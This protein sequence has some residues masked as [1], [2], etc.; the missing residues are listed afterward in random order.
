[1][2]RIRRWLAIEWVMIFIDTLILYGIDERYQHEH[3]GD[4]IS[5][6]SYLFA[7]GGC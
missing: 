5:Y 3:L 4:D 2:Q 1:M 7:M 6:I